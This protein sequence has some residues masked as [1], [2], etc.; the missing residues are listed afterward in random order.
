MSPR[1]SGDHFASDETD[2]AVAPSATTTNF[3][4]FLRLGRGLKALGKALLVLI[5]I[6]MVAHGI[7]SV[8]EGRKLESDLRAI[9]AKGEPVSPAEL[10]KPKVPDAENAAPIYAKAFDILA[11]TKYDSDIDAMFTLVAPEKRKPDPAIW[12]EVEKGL[13]KHPEIVPMIEQASARPRCQFPIR[14]EDGFNAAFP[15]LAHARKASALLAARA[16]LQSHRGDTAGACHSLELGF[17]LSDSLAEQPTLIS[18]LVRMAVIT[19]QARALRE[20]MADGGM[21]AAQAR[22]LYD[23]LGGIDLTPAYVKAMQTERMYGIWAFDYIRR[24]PEEL[25]SLMSAP[26]DQR[27]K[28]ALFKPL[29]F[30]W[31]PLSYM[32]ERFYL[33][34]MNEVVANAAMPYLEVKTR[35]PKVDQEPQYRKCFMVSCMITPYLGRARIR[36]DSTVAEVAGSRIALALT[37]YKNRFGAYPTS[38]GELRSKL[39]WDVPLDPFSG[40]DFVYKRQGSGYLLY[41]IGQNLKDDGARAF[42]QR[43]VPDDAN[44]MDENGQRVADIVWEIDR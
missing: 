3:P 30:L 2:G 40:K 33:Q 13:A 26:D 34:H 41:S 29:V 18:Q 25:P 37:A 27:Q 22:G 35:H 4:T 6:G 17:R 39:G 20:V 1:N 36:R 23:L 24:H 43:P 44:Y 5:V 15:H 9:K 14:W 7:A 32:D 38:L 28:N 8:V 19:I 16:M 10:G 12:D 21:T 42:T 31:R 11:D